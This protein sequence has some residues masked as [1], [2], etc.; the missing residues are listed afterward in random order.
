MPELP[1]KAV[2]DGIFGAVDTWLL[3]R[4][5]EQS[6][7][8]I[9]P[10]LCMLGCTMKNNAPMAKH[11]ADKN[12]VREL[13]T[14]Q[15]GGFD[16]SVLEADNAE[17]LAKWIKDH[18][19]S[20]DPELYEWLTP[21]V[22]SKWK[23]SAFKISQD[24]KTGAISRTKAVRMSF[25]TDRPFF[26]YREPEKKAK[27]ADKDKQVEA[28]EDARKNEKVKGE[29]PSASPRLLRVMFV[30]D[31]R[32]DGML[33][34]VTWSVQIPWSDALTEEQRKQLITETGVPE[35]SVLAGA[36]LTTFEDRS[37]PRPGKEEV[38]FEPSSN[39]VPVRPPDFIKYNDIWIPFDCT[40]VGVFF[41]G[42]VLVTIIRR[43]GKQPVNNPASNPPV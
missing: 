1:L 11:A 36:W 13:H 32:Y 43:L 7:L 6:R 3:P 28:K 14:Q 30:S 41:L 33:G 34:A 35:D 20:S 8:K 10:M 2:E 37:S 9:D 24:A 26:P 23:I 12:D 4:T 5:V 42:L 17:A 40:L 27:L 16:V 22:A 15:V 38:Y 29:T 21:Y 18:G 39:R 25:K 19:Y 31:G